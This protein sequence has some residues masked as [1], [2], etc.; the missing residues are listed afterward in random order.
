MPQSLAHINV[1]LIFSTKHRERWIADSV[2]ESLHAYMARVVQTLEGAPILINS[3]EDHAPLL[4]DLGRKA[5]ISKAVEEIKKS[6]SKWIKTQGGAFSGFAWQTGYGAFSVSQS[7]VNAVR[8]YI[9]NQHEHHREKT[10]QDE[11]RVFLKR[12]GIEYDERYVWD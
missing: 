5:S 4:F 10:F 1:H 3:V 9:A 8:R 11:F 2:R 6:P 7:N 12:H